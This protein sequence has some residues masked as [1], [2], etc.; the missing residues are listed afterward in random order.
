MSRTSRWALGFALLA[1]GSLACASDTKARED[2]E[3]WRKRGA[4][5]YYGGGTIH[6]NSFPETYGRYGPGPYGRP[7]GY[8]Y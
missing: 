3:A 2:E 5:G 8:G 1:A 6:S 4:E 7:M